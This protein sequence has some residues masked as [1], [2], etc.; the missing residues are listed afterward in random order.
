MMALAAP[1]RSRHV[2]ARCGALKKIGGVAQTLPAPLICRGI[3]QHEPGIGDG[4]GR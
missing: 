3:V 2:S 1:T 4:H